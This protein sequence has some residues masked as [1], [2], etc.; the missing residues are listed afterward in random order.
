MTQLFMKITNQMV[1]R[2]KKFI[3]KGEKSFKNIWTRP[4]G[5]L[6]S[7]LELCIKLNQEYLKQ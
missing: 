6:I 1:N 5:E 2:C 4:P 7:T 3:M